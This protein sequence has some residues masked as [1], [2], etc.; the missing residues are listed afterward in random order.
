MENQKEPYVN[1]LIFSGGSIA[2][3]LF[4]GAIKELHNQ[5]VWDIENIKKMHST[6]VGSVISLLLSLKYNW[7]EIDN[8]IIMRP[9]HKVFK[10]DLASI[11]NSVDKVG[12]FN[13]NSFHESFDTLLLGK[14]LE[15]NITMKE[16]YEFTGIE[17][18]FICTDFNNMSIVDV[19]YKTYP[20][21]PVIDAIYGS[22][23]LPIL[24]KP[25]VY[26]DLQLC[27]GGLTCNFPIELG[28]NDSKP[29]ETIVIGLDDKYAKFNEKDNLFS[30]LFTLSLNVLK[31][32]N[33]QKRNN[34]F[35]S[36]VYFDPNI[37][38]FENTIH[39][40]SESEKRIEM[41][42]Q[43]INKVK[44]ITGCISIED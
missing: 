15:P 13:V 16:L 20:D 32:I 25:V 40:F 11:F 29:E 3:L 17:N 38:N 44:E 27:D 43:G 2:G 21:F 4:Y 1:N 19:C 31:S 41:I 42:Q 7:D 22:C 24:F 30:Y 9:W 33:I 5:K 18:H 39:A 26:R 10:L 28:L 37:I 6:S 12:I 34:S 14:G 36:Q 8:F 23:C 35:K